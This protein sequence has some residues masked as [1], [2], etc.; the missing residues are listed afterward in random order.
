MF[1]GADSRLRRAPMHDF[2]SSVNKYVSRFLTILRLPCS[3]A[4]M[5]HLRRLLVEPP[6]LS[7]CLQ[8][9]WTH[10]PPLCSALS[11]ENVGLTGLALTAATT[12]TIWILST[13]LMDEQNG[14]TAPSGSHMKCWVDWTPKSLPSFFHVRCSFLY[15]IEFQSVIF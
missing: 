8:I 11:S 15:K 3:T 5:S 2:R 10:E 9:W 4:K 7:T 1:G 14:F 12:A 13:D 6:H